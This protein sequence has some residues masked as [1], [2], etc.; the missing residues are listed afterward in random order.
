[1]N[2]RKLTEEIMICYRCEQV[3]DPL[4]SE[5]F[6]EDGEIVKVL[7]CKPCQVAAKSRSKHKN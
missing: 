2:F 6:V 3:V 5:A 1:M 4:F 7:V